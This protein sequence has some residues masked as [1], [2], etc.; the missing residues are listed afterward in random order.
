MF[1]IGC[2]LILLAVGFCCRN[3]DGLDRRLS[4]G[5]FL[6]ALFAMVLGASLTNHSIYIFVFGLALVGASWVRS[7]DDTWSRR[8][9]K[10]GGTAILAGGCVVVLDLFQSP[11]KWQS[12]TESRTDWTPP[13]IAKLS[14]DKLLKLEWSTTDKHS[15]WP[16]AQLM[17]DLCRVSYKD[18]VDAREELRQIGFKP[19]ETIN[20][21]SMN[22]YVVDAGDDAIIVF[23]GT[24]R[25]EY[26]ILQ[27]LRFL[28]A[29]SNQ[30]S[31][32]GGFK[33]GYDPM[34]EQVRKLLQRFQPKGVWI[35]GH[36][37]GGALAIACSH[38]LLVDDKYAIAGVMTFGQP[39]V[40]RDELASFLAPRL[41]GK[42]VFFVNDMDPI[43][44]LIR[45]YT[46]FGHM[47]RWKDGTIERSSERLLVGNANGSDSNPTV[48]NNGA[49]YPSAMD[50][51]ELDELL[52][53]MENAQEPTYDEN[54]RPLARGVFPTPS[55]HYLKSY[56]DMLEHLR[57]KSDKSP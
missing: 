28:K 43:T 46:H 52:Q 53:Q 1:V 24:E 32:H 40:V 49:P 2:I 35:T 42:Y 56:Q 38:R 47:V 48:I 10:V 41:R 31:M 18:P 3:F 33:K 4:W 20:S 27:D 16:V 55:D 11:W 17:L 6:A 51:Q 54:G 15:H 26:D 25:S 13:P 29:N 22:G 37:L 57:T 12:E 45:P 14:P 36:S 34:H 39:M 23:R 9:R 30:G 50:D 19:S 8:F 44:R 7:V 21:G 5:L